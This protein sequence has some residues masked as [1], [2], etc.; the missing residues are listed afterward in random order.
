MFNQK[1]KP[2]PT[3]RKTPTGGMI[4]ESTTRKQSIY[5]SWYLFRQIPE[6][7]QRSLSNWGKIV[8]VE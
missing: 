3:W 6:I 7:Q 1:W 2:K 4:N 5:N 8:Y